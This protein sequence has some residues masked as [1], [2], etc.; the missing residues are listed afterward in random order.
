MLACCYLL[1]CRAMLDGV[2]GT[3]SND[4]AEVLLQN[5][6]L[7]TALAECGKISNYP[8]WSQGKIL[9]PLVSSHQ[10]R[11]ISKPHQLV[12]FLGL[13]TKMPGIQE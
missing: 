11:S 2:A 7:G 1:V 12:F 13:K 9:R 3:A 6:G 5:L 4:L 10:E 8:S